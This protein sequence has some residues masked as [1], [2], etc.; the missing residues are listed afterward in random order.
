[1]IVAEQRLDVL[2]LYDMQSMQT[3]FVQKH[4]TSISRH[5]AHRIHF[6]SATHD[7]RADFP[8]E[9]FDAIIIHFSVRLPWE[10][11][12]AEEFANKLSVFKGSKVLLIQ[13]EYDLP[14]KTCA[15]IRRLGVH[16]VF[17]TVPPE[18]R[19]QFYPSDSVKGVEFRQC[20]TG[21]VPDDLPLENELPPIADRSTWV[22]YRGRKLPI[23]YGTLAQEKHLIGLQ[24]KSLCEA[25]SV[26][27][28][29]E[30]DED[31]RIYGDA[32]YR[33]LMSSRV[34]LGTESGSNVVDTDGSIRKTAQEAWRESPDLS[35]DEIYS[36]HIERYDNR[37]RMNQ[38]SPKIFE[39]IALKTGLVLFEGDYSGILRPDDHFIPLQKDFSNIDEVL[40]KVANCSY[41]QAMVDRAYR[42]IVATG[43]YTYARFVSEIDNVLPRFAAQRPE[44]RTFV[45]ALVEASGAN[46]AWS[47]T[48]LPHVPLTAPIAHVNQQAPLEPYEPLLKGPLR[49]AWLALPERLRH[50]II[51]SLGSLANRLLRRGD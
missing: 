5:S 29:I 12:L 34:T 35:E 1:M 7:R 48:S 3:L 14:A 17:T 42:D 22:G 45:Y 27:H 18:Y 8:F 6:V 46:V 37:V 31:K 15:A 28:D 49:N 21:Y 2:V 47:S 33:F 9:L 20:Y 39:A 23:W 40:C 50:P 25:R 16:H 26:P 43:Q 11:I 10:G 30:W 4:L 19:D 32:W 36:D 44:Q 13:D 41:V 51:Q 38:I 24:M